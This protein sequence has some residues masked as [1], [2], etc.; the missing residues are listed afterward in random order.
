MEYLSYGKLNTFLT[1]PYRYKWVFLEEKEYK[2]VSHYEEVRFVNSLLEDYFR[3]LGI[4]NIYEDIEYFNKRRN[5]LWDSTYKY[6]LG[7]DYY[8][9]G[10]ALLKTGDLYRFIQK[11]CINYKDLVGVGYIFNF[12]IS[13]LKARISGKFTL[14]IKD[15]STITLHDIRVGDNIDL[16][17]SDLWT[18]IYS[19]GLRTTFPDYDQYKIARY[20]LSDIIEMINIE[21]PSVKES[22]ERIILESS[23]LLETEVYK[24]T[25]NIFCKDCHINKVNKCPIGGKDEKNNK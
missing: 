10:K 14:L 5:E 21:L 13:E 16:H 23:K 4:E 3:H 17:M 8:N 11:S 1:C 6:I 18:D 25:T 20:N 22:K 7:E 2:H 19:Y 9:D 12:Y 15:H 24:P